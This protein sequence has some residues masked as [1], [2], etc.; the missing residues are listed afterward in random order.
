M[1]SKYDGLARIIIQN[2]GG[3][4]NIISVTHC[5]TRL[6]FQLKDES[7]ANTD[8]LKQTDGVISVIQAN[9]QYQVVIG[10]TVGDVY[11]AVLDVGHLSG[12]GSVDEAGNAVAEDDTAKKK[13]V[14][15]TLIDL[16]SGIMAPTIALLGASGIIKGL[17]TLFV[18]LG[19][20][21]TSKGEYMILYT[22]ADGFFY[23]LPVI[24]GY[25]AAKKFKMNEFIGM[26]LG[27]AYCYPTMVNITSSEVLGTLFA[28]TS[29]EMS[30]YTT[31][32]NIP[33]IMPKSGYT[34]SVIPI[35][36]TI[37]I[38]A[39]LEK[40]L[41][42]HLHDLIR[43]FVTPVCVLCIMASLS[44][45]VIGPI[46]NLICCVLTLVFNALFSIPGIGA[47]LGC[48][49]VGGFW[50]FLVIFG[51]HW[52]VIPLGY[53]NIAALGYDFIM[54]GTFATPFAQAGSLLAVLVKTKDTK[55]KKI[56][57]PAFISCMFGIT[58]P[59][60][61]GIN[62]PKKKPFV[63]AS[64]AAAIAGAFV[65]LMGAKRY[66]PGG[67]GLFGAPGY[68]DPGETGLYSMWVVLIASLIA[69]IIAFAGSFMVYKEDN[70][71]VK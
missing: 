19:W 29:F 9:G 34:S 71:A 43:S 3:K 37:F 41:N 11:D 13:G 33:V 50:Q 7:K 63:A 25:T 30:Y 15:G 48:A 68:I 52:S 6:R 67:L 45:L 39:K 54:P 57:I 44:Y 22:V 35:I 32:F 46:S 31:F 2:V 27:I 66:V 16:I 42:N 24:L 26:A 4:Q 17:L 10:N 36:I 12:G 23:F 8:M 64:I 5:I 38:A 58:E 60:I 47:V 61:Y 70:A 1:A 69:F 65:G 59:A 55:L 18:F 28:G 51:F 56:G 62:L 14:A 53:I 20:M 49:V 21:D 40:W